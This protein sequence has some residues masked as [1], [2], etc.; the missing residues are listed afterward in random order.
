MSGTTTAMIIILF[1]VSTGTAA[2]RVVKL[3]HKDPQTV[4][5]SAGD[6]F[7]DALTVVGGAYLIA[8]MVFSTGFA[9]P[10]WLKDLVPLPVWAGYL[11]AGLIITVT[12]L[13]TVSVVLTNRVLDMKGTDT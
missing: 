10:A 1:M 12:G 6:Q 8:S 3:F 7:L 13:T 2:Q 4:R 11:I 5:D 9:N